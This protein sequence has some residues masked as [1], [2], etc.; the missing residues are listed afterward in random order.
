MVLLCGLAH[1]QAMEKQ[2]EEYEFLKFSIDDIQNYARD[3]TEETGRKYALVKKSYMVTRYLEVLGLNST[4]TPLDVRY[5]YDLLTQKL[6]VDEPAYSLVKKAYNELVSM[7]SAFDAYNID[8]QALVMMKP[9]QV[10]TMELENVESKYQFI[11]DKGKLIKNTI[12]V[13]QKSQQHQYVPKKSSALTQLESVLD[14]SADA[15][16]D[17]IEKAYN[18]YMENNSVNRLIAL[19]NMNRISSDSLKN[20]MS[21]IEKVKQ[22]YAQYLRE[23]HS[24]K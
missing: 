6:S 10:E 7:L 5:H 19:K 22:A 13:L 12:K 8:L 2:R 16:H 20:K 14:I 11:K 24:F 21:E 4:N 15:S 18:D 3:L 17:E 9:K 23:T 1:L